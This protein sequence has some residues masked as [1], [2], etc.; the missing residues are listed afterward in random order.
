M[1]L[2]FILNEENYAMKI[3]KIIIISV[4]ILTG[5]ATAP[6]QDCKPV[7]L[8]EIIDKYNIENRTSG[9]FLTNLY[10]RDKSDHFMLVIPHFLDYYNSLGAI[11]IYASPKEAAIMIVQIMMR[12]MKKKELKS[13]CI[14]ETIIEISSHDFLL[15]PTSVYKTMPDSDFKDLLDKSFTYS[16][17]NYW[18]DFS[19]WIK[20]SPYNGSNEVM[21]P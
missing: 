3:P 11:K 13:G 15:M 1:D 7:M 18:N 17:R 19:N 5:T 4:L 10:K 12:D 14:W 9:E 20:V 21:I 16:K 2:G 6:G 8:K